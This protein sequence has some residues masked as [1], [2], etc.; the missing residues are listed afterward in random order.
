LAAVKKGGERLHEWAFEL[1]AFR[2]LHG[3]EGG[4]ISASTRVGE[5]SLANIGA[6]VM[7]NMFGGHPGP[8]HAKN[9]WNGW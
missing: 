6:T 5:E 7:H 3:L 2:A 4:E 1:A 8:W 9:P